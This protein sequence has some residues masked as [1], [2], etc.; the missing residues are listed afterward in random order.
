MTP[1]IDFSKIRAERGDQREGFE[2]FSA[3]IFHRHRVAAGSRYERYRGAGGD[4]GVEAIWRLPTGKVIGLQSKYFLPLKAAHLSQL[5]KSLDTALDNHPDLQTYI[6]TLPFDPTPTV[7]ARKGEGQAEKLETWRKGLI[8]RAAKR[9]ITIEVEWW[10][11]SELKSR[12]LSMDNSDGRIL[13]WFGS[14]HLSMATLKSAATVAEG[15]AGPRYSPRLRVGN[16]AGDTI[17]AF[18]LDPT[19]PAVHQSW[20]ERLDKAVRVW[21][22]M[23]PK[24]HPAWSE[25]ILAALNDAN[26]RFAAVE[27][28]CFTEA[29]RLALHSLASHMLPIA[30]SLEAAVKGEFDSTHGAQ[31]D[32]IRW[33]QF[34]AAYQCVFPAADL[35]HA[36]EACAL[37]RDILTFAESPAAIAAGADILLMRGA[38]GIGKTH[39]TIDATKERISA[40]RGALAILGQEITHGQ[41]LWSVVAGK[42]GIGPSASK[43]EILG[44][45]AAFTEGTNAPFLICVD[46]INETPDRRQWRSWLP[47]LKLDLVG[48][49]IKLLLTC[50]DIFIEDALGA[51]ADDLP[52]F[53]HT[54]FAGREYD[55]A[56]AFAAFYKVG[57]PAEVVAQPE[58]ANPLFLHLICRAAVNM[59][60][61]RIPSGQISLIKLITAI[62]DGANEKA[63]ELLDFDVRIENPVR[64]GA[65]ALAKAMGQKGV[66]LLPLA[67]A[68]TILA[69]VRPS[70]GASRSLLRAMEE[71]DLVSVASDSGAPFLQFAFERL[72]DV[73]IAQATITGQDKATVCTRFLSGDLAALVTT[74]DAVSENAGLI[75]AYSILLPELH[76]IE[77]A[78]LLRSTT[79]DLEVT[80]LALGVLAWRDIASFT[81]TAWVLHH[82]RFV[83]L[84]AVLDRVLAVA[85]VPEHP[86]NAKWLNCW[87]RSCQPLNRDALWTSALK[88]VW[89]Q[90]GAGYQLVSI[91]R[92]QVLSHLSTKSAVLLGMALAWFTGSADLLIRDEASEALTR[93]LVAQS[94]S[95]EL[96]G[97]FV[98]CD[99]DFVRERVLNS[100]YGA[101]LL[102]QDPAYWGK[103]AD[104]VFDSFFASGMPPEN[105]LLRDLGRLIVEEGIAAGTM[106]NTPAPASVQPPYTS[107]WP[108]QFMF[109]DWSALDVAHPDLPT[110]LNLGAQLQP[111]FARYVV[112]PAA[113]DFNLAAAGLTL[114][115]LNQWIVEQILMLGY[116][117]SEKFALAYDWKLIEEHGQERGVPNRHRRVSKKHQWIFLA[118]LLG[119][120]HD[121]VSHNPPS[122]GT[123]RNPTDLQAAELRTVD[124]TDLSDDLA[125][126][127][128]EVKVSDFFI[129][130]TTRPEARDPKTWTAELFS[131][132]DIKLVGEKW[133]L[134]AGYQS[135][136]YGDK[137]NRHD[138]SASRH[139]AAMLVPVR[140]MVALKKS[141]A[142]SIPNLDIPELSKLYQG[143][144]PRSAALRAHS[145]QWPIETEFGIPASVIV[146]QFDHPETPVHSLW[147][148]ASDLI[149][150]NMARWDGARKW[151]DAS[152]EV[153]A[154]QIGSGD[155]VALVFDRAKLL[156]YLTVT[157]SQIVWV[158]DESRNASIAYEPVAYSDLCQ[159]WCWSGKKL[160]KLAET[161]N[162]YVDEDKAKETGKLPDDD[163]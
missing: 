77:I 113:R 31:N 37:L 104:I 67:D 162:S 32:N 23:A 110:N 132:Q 136:Q 21:S 71:A 157:K 89:E 41:N 115:D 78:D 38:A 39:T 84:I 146:S 62:L 43:S 163:S 96:L 54:G 27:N 73:L 66:R 6:V 74:P 143:E 8:D 51:A 1:D 155:D 138:L 14:P 99:D 118:R 91:A 122:W 3:Q 82:S 90:R 7:K 153:V 117:G 26:L 144:F 126:P 160:T 161:Q 86:V 147:A 10:H 40:G 56:Y 145:N 79:T 50:R 69:G 100:A 18:G 142:S 101:G 130:P 88:Q 13:Y 140:E 11:E 120:L 59:R 28:L 47:Q 106:A 61:D 57:P 109:P 24:A 154:A 17:K 131:S 124:P 45:L 58:F 102:K 95:G 133:L 149:T 33:R 83:D 63:A 48:Q 119:R 114:A 111:D 76:G 68:Q 16:D 81:S 19:W 121:H 158:L 80:M 107:T 159:A 94:I 112:E 148:P 55:A 137:A 2:E 85:A 134:L 116:D 108:L 151:M 87:L 127:L 20:V 135:W 128:P 22:G 35:D 15:V 156:A 97:Y 125:A 123:P 42:L 5:E 105:V 30:Q 44:V 92:G 139:V 64:D 36:R 65:Q 52:S 9:G 72:G 93:L 25:Q 60:W 53:M 4:G 49:P 129:M 103:I 141:F 150:H 70:Q 12:L 98:R 46:A 29:D 75:Q 34:Q 152:R